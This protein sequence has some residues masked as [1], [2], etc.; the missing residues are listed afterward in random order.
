VLP[1]L[2]KSDTPDAQALRARVAVGQGKDA[3]ALELA[4]AVLEDDVSQCDALLA[5]AEIHIRRRQGDS[6][7]LDA[8][9]AQSQCPQLVTGWNTLARAYQLKGNVLGIRRAY[10]QGTRLNQQDSQIARDFAVWQ[11]AERQPQRAL[12]TGRRLVRAAPAQ[13]SGWALYGEICRKTTDTDCA[14]EVQAG[15]AKAR[16]TL[17]IDLTPGER[18]PNGLFGRLRRL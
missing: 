13:L 17:G 14:A 7:V 1:L 12:A 18:P 4:D 8:Q 3:E 16:T 9:T 2:G 5:R 10:E 11:L 15:L 6:A